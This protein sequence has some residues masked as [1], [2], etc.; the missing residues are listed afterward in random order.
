MDCGLG[1]WSL[2][3]R[4]MRLRA[5]SMALLAVVGCAS[6]TQTSLL[7]KKAGPEELAVIA[8]LGYYLR[9]CEVSR[10][11]ANGE[12]T[13][14]LGWE[15][16]TIEQLD[17]LEAALV[18]RLQD[19]AAAL[20]VT[21]DDRLEPRV[22]TRVSEDHRRICDLAGIH[23]DSFLDVAVD[24]DRIDIDYPMSWPSAKVRNASV[25]VPLDDSFIWNG[26]WMLG[27]KRTFPVNACRTDGVTLPQASIQFEIELS[28]SL[29]ESPEREVGPWFSLLR[30]RR[31]LHLVCKEN[32]KWY[33]VGE[34]R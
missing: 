26:R 1:L 30:Q 6:V 2:W 13:Q 16:T 28:P 25:R 17:P 12:P 32:G 19:R 14:H 22:V 8:C 15:C 33:V 23:E 4:S 21:I 18:R 24:V 20:E 29:L 27:G 34:E 10:L 3:S 31:H 7:C 11:D 9:A 5:S